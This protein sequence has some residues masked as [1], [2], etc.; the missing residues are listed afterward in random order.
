MWWDLWLPQ[1]PRLES[2]AQLHTMHAIQHIRQACKDCLRLRATDHCVPDETS[3]SVRQSKQPFP[4]A[5]VWFVMGSPGKFEGA[6]LVASTRVKQDQALF[7]LLRTQFL[8]SKCMACRC[9]TFW[10]RSKTRVFHLTSKLGSDGNARTFRVSLGRRGPRI[11][12]REA[13]SLVSSH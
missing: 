11:P 12:G 13:Q 5:L 3:D 2:K 1:E 9:M 6:C 8:G 7:F 4:G 10:S